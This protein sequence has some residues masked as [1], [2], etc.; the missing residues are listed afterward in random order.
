MPY[1]N[2]GISQFTNKLNYLDAGD[3]GSFSTKIECQT[4]AS[5]F[6]LMEQHLHIEVWNANSYSL[7]TFLG[8]ESLK[9]IDVA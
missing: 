9:L 5:Y 7:N 3:K 2:K 8:Y 6:E 1:G 4:L